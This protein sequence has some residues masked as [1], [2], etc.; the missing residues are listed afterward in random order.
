MG[1]LP[2]G[3]DCALLALAES[4]E[5]CYK[6]NFIETC[7]KF[8]VRAFKRSHTHTHTHRCGPRGVQGV[9]Q[10]VR[11]FVKDIFCLFWA[12]VAMQTEQAERQAG[13]A[14]C[15]PST[16]TKSHSQLPI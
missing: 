5:M 12:I 6:L 10:G 8:F 9:A 16:A 11:V 1:A 7:L 3:G 15:R 2:S 13:I 4:V 14:K